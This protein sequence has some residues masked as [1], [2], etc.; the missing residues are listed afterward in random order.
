MATYKGILMPSLREE[1][2]FSLYGGLI[3]LLNPYELCWGNQQYTTNSI[4]KAVARLEKH[5]LLKKRRKENKI[6]LQLTERGKKTV[7]DHRK[8]GG[9]SRRTWDEKW[10]VVIFDVPEKRAEARRYL[11]YYLKALGFGKVQRSTWITPYN[12]E[13]LI[14][15]FSLKMKISE[16]VFQMTIE[17]FRGLTDVE[18]ARTFWPIKIINSE[19]QNLIKRYSARLIQ[20]QRNKD[21]TDPSK[22]NHGKRFLSSLLWDYQSIAARDP[23]L[24]AQLLP[25]DWSQK[26]ALDFI[27]R[28]QKTFKL[29]D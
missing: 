9:H 27:E 24:P 20:L 23:Q 29:L 5:G 14:D 7:R 19:Y 1:I 8:S 21:N 18:L 3:Y 28:T 26:K 6:Y 17:Q 13:K 2:L 16:C 11:R 4:Y 10:R 12:F 25:P 22:S 15:Y